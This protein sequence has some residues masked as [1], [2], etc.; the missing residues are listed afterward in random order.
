M[1]REIYTPPQGPPR[2][3]PGLSTLFL[4]VGEASFRALAENFYKEIAKSSIRDLFPEDFTKPAEHQADFLIQVTGGPAYYAEKRGPAR[5]RARHFQW[6]I[7]EEARQVWLGCYSIA[8]EKSLLNE[9]QK[10]ILWQFLEQFSLWMVNQK[11]SP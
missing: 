6:E 7:T 5:M 9:T 10:K 3:I 1:N 4:E 8:L 2:E 11:S